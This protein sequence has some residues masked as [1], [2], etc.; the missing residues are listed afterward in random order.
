MESPSALPLGEAFHSRRTHA[1]QLAGGAGRPGHAAALASCAG[2]AKALELLRDPVLDHLITAEADFADLPAA[3]PGSPPIPMVRS[4]CASSI[5]SPDQTKGKGLMYSVGVRDHVMI[6]HSFQGEVFGPAQKLHGGHLRHRLRV[7]QREAHQGQHRGR[8]RPRLR[9]A[10]GGLR[11]ISYQNLD[12]LKMF[13]GTN[14]TTEFLA[15]HVFDQMSAAAR[16]RSL[17][18]A[19]RALPR[20]R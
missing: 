8:H 10:E 17:D 13:E 12:D 19:R 4:A 5:R 9:Q 6:A 16:A 3:L 14:T 15:R 20:S 1:H 11:Q 18:L 2:L 7:P